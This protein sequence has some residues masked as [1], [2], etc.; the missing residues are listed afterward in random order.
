MLDQGQAEAAYRVAAGHAAEKATARLEAEWHAG[1]IALRFLDAPERA[2]PHFARAAALAETPVSIARAS[3]W[4]GRAF[5]ALGDAAAAE[6]HYRRAAERHVAY[7]GQIARARLGLKDVPLN[8][9]APAA[10]RPS[11]ALE[12][13]R[14]L[15]RA[16]ADAQART[17]A[18]DLARTLDDPAALQH[19]A[20]TVRDAADSRFLVNFGKAAIHRGLPL[21]R[22]AFPV[23]GIPEFGMHQMRVE[24]AMVFAIARQESA[25]DPA[26]MSHAGARGLMQMMLPTARETARR[27]GYGFDAGR[28]TRDAAYNAQ[29]GAAHL[30]DLLRDWRGSYILAFAAYNAGS[31]NVKDWIEAYGDPR[32]PEVDPIDWVERIPFT[33]TRHYV[34]RVME[35]LQIYRALV[36]GQPSLMMASDLRRGLRTRAFAGEALALAEN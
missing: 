23:C 4:Q 8:T 25:F 24:L 34:Q 28:L 6:A 17:L 20:E 14:L 36:D 3:Y 35:N 9:I 15:R 1:W 7:Y 30:A 13:L 32:R 26:A 16:G 22:V 27:F 21:E 18:L 10:D 12:A 2:L 33:E 5:E 19:A 29:L 11:E 31:G